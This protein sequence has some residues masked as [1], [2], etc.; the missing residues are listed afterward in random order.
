[1]KTEHVQERPDDARPWAESLIR[2]LPED[3]DGRNSW[4]LNYGISEEADRLRDEHPLDSEA[5]TEKG[6]TE[7]QTQEYTVA[8]TIPVY[9]DDPEAALRAFHEAVSESLKWAYEVE[10]S[11]GNTFTVDWRDNP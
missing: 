7:K 2:Q 11:D 3:H 8:L 6:R 1:M 9:G 10:D 5:F 4:L